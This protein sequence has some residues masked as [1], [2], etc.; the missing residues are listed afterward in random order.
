[1]MLDVHATKIEQEI[2]V[3][4]ATVDVPARF[5]GIPP[6]SIVASA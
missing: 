2:E 1:M 5:C 4:L 6:E 3:P